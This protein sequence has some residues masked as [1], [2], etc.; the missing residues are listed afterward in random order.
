MFI[1]VTC[2]LT[3]LYSALNHYFN[4]DGVY[5]HTCAK[6]LDLFHPGTHTQSAWQ[7]QAGKVNKL[8]KSFLS[9]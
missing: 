5:V 6:C 1:K 8:C 4:R 2:K 3:V 7:F 9:T